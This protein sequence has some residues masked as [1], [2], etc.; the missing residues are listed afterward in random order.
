MYKSKIGYIME[1]ELRDIKPH[2]RLARVLNLDSSS[3]FLYWVPYD[4]RLFFVTEG[5]GRI[6]TVDGTYEMNVGDMLFI[7]SG[8]AY[9]IFSPAER[10]SYLFISFDYVF[11]AADENVPLCPD[12]PEKFEPSR[13]PAHVTFE[14][15]PELSGTLHIGG[16]ESF[17][18]SISEI[19]HEFSHGGALREIS[20]SSKVASLLVSALRKHRSNDR[21]RHRR[22]DEILEYVNNN[23]H[24]PLINEEIAARFYYHP[25]YLNSIIKSETGK[26]LRE[27]INAVRVEH[28]ADM[29]L[30]TDKTVAEIAQLSGFYDM[31]HFIRCFKS[32]HGTTPGRSRASYI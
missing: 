31:P 32:L 7:N 13:M 26:S 5:S 16:A 28:A 12:V 10:V 18:E 9:K 19:I 23:Y 22:V 4:A 8:T 6:E 30:N 11:T 24:L 29:L 25:N 27:Y 17:T 20:L 14:D 2:V 21:K 15:A 1:I 3:K